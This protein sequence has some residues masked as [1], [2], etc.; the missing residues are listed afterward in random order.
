MYICVCIYI[1]IYNFFFSNKLEGKDGM[2]SFTPLH[3]PPTYVTEI[4]AKNIINF[5]IK[6]FT[7]DVSTFK[8]KVKK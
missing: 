6:T 7:I 1:Y 3:V 4:N 8:Y 5:I 2:R